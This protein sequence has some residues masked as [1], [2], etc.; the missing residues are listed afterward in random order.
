MY[1]KDS[2]FKTQM[3]RWHKVFKDE[4]KGTSMIKNVLAVHQILELQIMWL[5]LKHL[6]T[7]I[8]GWVSEWFR[9][10]WDLQNRLCIKSSRKTSNA[11]NLY[12]ID[13]KN[14]DRR[15]ERTPWIDSISGKIQHLN[16]L[17]TIV[18]PRSVIAKL[19]SIPS[20]KIQLK[21]HRFKNLENL[22]KNVTH[23][24]NSIPVED[25]QADIN[26]WPSRQRF[27]NVEGGYFKE[28]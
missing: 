12:R 9:R 13:F 2:S 25:F 11:K 28:H 20:I 8:V 19:F 17:L 4:K 18:Q 6:W 7:V 24:L 1:K 10:R 22:Q 14:F 16:A 27:I 15:I 26:G 23:F 3:F 5:K 21:G